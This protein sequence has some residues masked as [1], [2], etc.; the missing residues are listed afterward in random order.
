MKNEILLVFELI[1]IILGLLSIGL[2]VL[3]NK[4]NKFANRLLAGN[5][6][7][8]TLYM[9]AGALSQSDFFLHHPH[10]YRA[11]YP[12]NLLI[13]PL[14]YLYIRAIFTEKKYLTLK[15]SLH[16]VP[17]IVIALQFLPFYAMGTE[18]KRQYLQMLFTHPGKLTLLNEGW[19]PSGTISIIV[20]AIGLIYMVFAI[21]IFKEA[22][23]NNFYLLE[24]SRERP[25]ILSWITALTFTHLIMPF[26]YFLMLVI[27]PPMQ[28]RYI[29]ILFVQS[30]LLSSLLVF[31]F[32]R[33]QILYGLSLNIGPENTN[34]G[35]YSPNSKVE[36][37]VLF[38]ASGKES[39]GITVAEAADEEEYP[40]EDFS[41]DRQVNDI[42]KSEHF[43]EYAEI[44]ER[45]FSEEKI[46]LKR[47]F[48]LK[49]L[50]ALTNIPQHHLTI[51]FNKYWGMRFNDYLNKCRVNYIIGNI[52]DPAWSNL[53]LEGI[54]WQAGFSS[55]ITFFKAVKKVTGLSPSALLRRN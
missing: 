2:L 20:Y 49:D 50:S 41:G 15:D 43:L 12:F 8:T 28:V 53:S 24:E 42:S 5:I 11:F 4:E 55:R 34:P 25:I 31:L 16:L 17:A 46:F 7:C 48:A 21:R 37:P 27:S 18:E 14:Y 35:S 47:G 6:A 52:N 3:T 51:L 9:C 44:V 45:C 29:P 13:Y 22:R 40:E 1:T 23:Q 30:F 54:A 19:L 10:F 39:S 36:P 38:I 26:L 32:I 33:P